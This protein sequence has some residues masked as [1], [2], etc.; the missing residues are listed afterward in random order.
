MTPLLKLGN[1][2]CFRYEIL[3]PYVIK[4]FTD[5]CR[6]SHNHQIFNTPR[7]LRLVV[8]K[9]QDL[10]IAMTIILWRQQCV[11][12]TIPTIIKSSNRIFDNLKHIAKGIIFA[13]QVIESKPTSSSL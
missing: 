7:Q 12:I 9:I 1:A 5:C 11:K 13:Q 4:N 2:A 6:L 10:F 8:T 3:T